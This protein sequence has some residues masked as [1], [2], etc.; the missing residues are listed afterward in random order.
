MDQDA[1]RASSCPLSLQQD[2]S[3]FWGERTTHHFV[4]LSPPSG[5]ILSF[6]PFSPSPLPLRQ[7][8]AHRTTATVRS[9]KQLDKFK[10]ETIGTSGRSLPYVKT[11]GSSPTPTQTLKDLSKLNNCSLPLSLSLPPSLS[12]SL[13]LPLSPSLSLSLPL[14]LSLSLSLSFSSPLSLSHSVSLPSDARQVYETTPF[15]RHFYDDDGNKISF[16]NNDTYRQHGER[17]GDHP[18]LRLVT[19]S[20]YEG[21]P[22]CDFVNTNAA[23]V[24]AGIPKGNVTLGDILG[25]LRF[26]NM[27]S[28]ARIKGEQILAL[29]E[30]EAQFYDPPKKPS[31]GLVHAMGLRYAWNPK[32][33]KF[34][35]VVGVQVLDRTTKTWHDL[36]DKK[37]YKILTSS[38]LR[39]RMF[40]ASNTGMVVGD[41]E[42][43]MTPL[44]YN[45]FYGPET[46]IMVDFFRKYSPY[47]PHQFKRNA[48]DPN[49]AALPS[50]NLTGE[51]EPKSVATLGMYV[52]H[53]DKK[54]KWREALDETGCF[55][56]KTSMNSTFTGQ[57]PSPSPTTKVETADITT[58]ITVVVS[59]GSVLVLLT[60]FFA[61]GKHE[62]DEKQK[63][64]ARVM[65]EATKEVEK[66]KKEK[67]ALLEEKKVLEKKSSELAA[68]NSKIRKE[69]KLLNW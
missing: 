66:E 38:Y 49:S 2:C 51:V 15:L 63:V 24:G 5:S 16:W 60:L 40:D 18:L 48:S 27:I 12:L 36:N 32:G 54:D 62:A 53:G 45:D 31:G 52:C 41:A 37:I 17:D 64:F 22:D 61:Y 34:K 11:V 29:L 3:F 35:R 8:I 44:E 1:E 55:I 33:D 50:W 69:C 19:A 7:P 59:I 28:S 9:F 68:Q 14:S 23:S 42:I 13:S 10:T 21:C 30:W 43:D 4:L 67:K 25:I 39:G 58:V 20:L 47:V 57:S 46:E 65:V 26:Q 6:A 56:V